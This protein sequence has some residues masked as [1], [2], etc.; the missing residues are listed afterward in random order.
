MAGADAGGISSVV[1]NYYRYIDRE[2]FHFD[3]AV[4]TD[5]VGQNGRLL[6]E[7]GTRIYFLPRKSKGLRAFTGALEALL[8][9]EHFDA[10]H[11]HENETSYVALR[12]AKR[13]GLR[14][15]IAH[16]H[17]SSPTTSMASEL[18]RLTGCFLN[19][20][21]ATAV[22]GCGQLAGERV[23]G[24]RNMRRKKAV[25]LPNAIDAEKFRYDS[26]ERARM[27]VELGVASNY[28]IGM[29]GR[30][31]PEKNHLFVLN[32]MDSVCAADRSA[33]LLIA[34]NGPDEEMLRARIKEKKLE[35]YV[36]LL[37]RRE[38]VDKLYQAFDLFIMPSI[39]EGFPLAAVEAIASG[40][41]VLL[42]DTI[43]RELGFSENVQ[44]IPLQPDKWVAA[45]TE[46]A[47]PE[48]R[49]VGAIEIEEQGLD[50]R[51]TAKMLETVYE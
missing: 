16:A 28:V 42:S 49:S 34:G 35:D 51:T 1:L 8:T 10:I 7:L 18:R 5:Q 47:C 36:I 30:L 2:R 25:I 32:V 21:Y 44:Y 31:G 50:I 27:R 33:K 23:F 15:R 45:I 22:I 38:D 12:T 13:V 24:K 29:V 37:G 3:I 43:T 9:S 4:T 40:L 26:G 11:V 6:Q 19:C 41:P 20:H 39:H 46:S 17:T 48:N 14:C